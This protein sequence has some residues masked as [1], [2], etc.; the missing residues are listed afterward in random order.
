[1]VHWKET[2][3]DYYI[4]GLKPTSATSHLEALAQTN[5]HEKRLLGG[6]HLNNVILTLHVPVYYTFT[7]HIV[8]AR[9]NFEVHMWKYK[10]A[11]KFPL[12]K[13]IFK[14]DFPNL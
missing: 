2:V 14:I 1:M 6:I 9:L 11:S 3:A 8:S 12:L 13:L 10:F 7:L 4:I 5:C